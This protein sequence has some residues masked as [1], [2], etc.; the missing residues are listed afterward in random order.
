MLNWVC[1]AISRPWSQV[2]ERRSC[3]GS[4]S[5][6]A[7]SAGHHRPATQLQMDTLQRAGCY[8]VFTETASRGRPDRATDLGVCSG[9]ASA[10][11]V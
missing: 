6:A 9:C 10:I 1:S 7:V 4:R 11:A 5:T 2:N 3:S 8:R